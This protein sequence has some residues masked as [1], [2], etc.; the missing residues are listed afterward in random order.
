M[1]AEHNICIA[2]PLSDITIMYTFLNNDSLYNEK[3][4]K[5]KKENSFYKLNKKINAFFTLLKP[6]VF[7]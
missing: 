6:I 7:A 4:I 5:P 1:S 2:P 3:V